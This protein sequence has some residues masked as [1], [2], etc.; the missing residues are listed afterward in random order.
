MHTKGKMT[1]RRVTYTISEGLCQ[2]RERAS[3]MTRKSKSSLVEHAIE[4]LFSDKRKVL[5][6]RHTQLR[7]EIARISEEFE[8]QFPE[9]DFN[10]D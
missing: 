6:E 8:R 10:P 2:A 5:R 9:E 1:K 7:H 3:S 4:S